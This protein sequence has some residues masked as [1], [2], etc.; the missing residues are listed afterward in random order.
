MGSIETSNDGAASQ[1][2]RQ[3]KIFTLYGTQGGER[4]AL[5]Q[6]GEGFQVS[7]L[8]QAGLPAPHQRCLLHLSPQVGSSLFKIT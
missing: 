5:Q 8:P 7:C 4:C 1:H 6:E 2:W 3:L